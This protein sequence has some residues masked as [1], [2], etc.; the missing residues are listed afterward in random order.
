MDQIGGNNITMKI[1][2][3]TFVIIFTILAFPILD[4]SASPTPISSVFFSEWGLQAV[5][6]PKVWSM[7]IKGKG[8]T[9]AVVDTGVDSSIGDLKGNLIPGYNALTGGT[10]FVD[11]VDDNGHGTQV[12]S[13]IVGNGQGL[14]LFG[15]APE[16]KILPVKVFDS[17]GDGDVQSVQSG[18]RWATDNG[19]KIINLSM[20]SSTLDVP[21]QEAIKYAQ[22]KDCLIVAAVGN[23]S[24]IEEPNILYPASFPAVIAVGA[25]TKDNKIAPFSNIGYN[26]DLVA[27]GT[28]ILTDNV[29]ISG[30]N[31]LIFNDGTSM[32][33]PFVSGVAALIWSAHP[34]WSAQQV[35]SNIEQSA[36]RL[37]ISGR[38]S[39]FGFGLPNAYRAIKIANLQTLFSPTTI[40]YAGGIIKDASSGFSL[41]VSPLTWNS[42][43]MVNLQSVGVPA[44]FPS[45]I[46]P[47]SA[48][49][50]VSWDTSETPHKIFSLSIPVTNQSTLVN[51]LFRWDGSRW[52]RVG[53]GISGSMLTVGIFEQGI[54]RI[55]QMPLT[56]S[57]HLQRDRIATAIEIA[58]TA[59]PTGADT[60]ILARADDYSD[61]LAGVPLAYKYSAPI[62]LNYP[63]SLDPRVESEI[64]HLAPKRIYLLGGT[65]AI[66]AEIESNLS[67]IASVYRLAGENRYATAAQIA[68]TLGTTGKAVI[69]N[70]ESFPDALSIASIAALRG[71]P[72]LLT[73]NDNSVPLETLNTLNNL[74]VTDT[75][76][77]GGSAVVSDVA[78]EQLP[79]PVRLAGVDR[80]AT[81]HMVIDAFP[82]AGTINID[83][84]GEDYSDALTSAVLSAVTNSTFYLINQRMSMP[85]GSIRIG[86]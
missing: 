18:I 47:C 32:A 5:D 20:G 27:P 76:V 14:G 56:T 72:I 13:L 52:I 12:A 40:D 73:D 24:D 25:L 34:D 51:Y 28:Q 69:V 85:S 55:G 11:T 42:T 58:N 41:L 44:P 29:G 67:R 65:K 86:R 84:Y 39:Q 6:A 63:D 22:V 21:L 10:S 49:V 26:L 30:E 4:V 62:L 54:Y 83:D 7:G 8:I 9:I 80:Y 68:Q 64:Q 82:S 35:I 74:W 71:E 70:G 38:S 15:V 75:L 23:H 59:Y 77:V 48:T 81:N 45:G 19:A 31:K 57:F 50:R 3:T 16:A 43:S 60:L 37:D 79:G 53:G 2:L 33:A 66:S 1:R 17:S 78:M 46:I 36:Q 61:A